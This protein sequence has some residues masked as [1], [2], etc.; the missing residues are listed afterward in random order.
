MNGLILETIVKTVHQII[1]VFVMIAIVSS[2]V[3]SAIDVI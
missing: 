3:V 1:F 2:I